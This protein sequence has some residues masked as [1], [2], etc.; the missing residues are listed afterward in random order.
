[1]GAP[2]EN[3]M[4]KSKANTIKV[5]KGQLANTV[6]VKIYAA[7]DPGVPE[8]PE[9]IGWSAVINWKAG[10]IKNKPIY[11]GNLLDLV[12]ECKRFIQDKLIDLMG[13][14]QEVD[15]IFKMPSVDHKAVITF[16]GAM[17]SLQ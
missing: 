14:I 8:A 2:R 5:K 9:V 4:A 11:G 15:C 17:R 16:K 1:M 13:R 7:I 6:I 3:I 12:K 10:D